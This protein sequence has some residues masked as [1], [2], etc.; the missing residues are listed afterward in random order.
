MIAMLP[1]LLMAGEPVLD[2][3]N[4]MTQMAMNRCAYLDNEAA[5]AALNAQ[6]KITAAAMK[7]RDTELDRDYDMRQG[8]FD[9]LL[10]A[11]RAW[12]AYRDAHC[13]NEGYFARG[14]SMEPML[15]SGCLTQLTR[16]RTAQLAELVETY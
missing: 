6:W 1:L 14:G 5:D 4:A 15:V 10:A 7:Q 8:H 13:R 9:T 16:V 2:C 11:Q 12:M 3:E